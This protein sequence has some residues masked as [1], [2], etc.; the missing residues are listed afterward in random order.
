MDDLLCM[1]NETKL[2][3]CTYS[4]MDSDDSHSEDA[5]VKCFNQTSACNIR[6]SFSIFYSNYEAYIL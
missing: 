5:G 4:P 2:I 3:D 1:G 6:V